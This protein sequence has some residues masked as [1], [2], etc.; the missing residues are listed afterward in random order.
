MKIK[1]LTEEDEL[2]DEEFYERLSFLRSEHK[3]TLDI[4]ERLYKRSS[5]TPIDLKT[6]IRDQRKH[7]NNTRLCCLSQANEF[8]SNLLNPRTDTQYS[9][10][11][12]EN[13]E[14]KYLHSIDSP[15]EGINKLESTKEFQLNAASFPKQSDKLRN[16][17]LKEEAKLPCDKCKHC[18]GLP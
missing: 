9:K 3:D 17:D 7:E 1:K 6:D 2:T 12:L 5:H 4:I 18:Y 15:I 14:P 16:G 11:Y 13:Y 10:R 8:P